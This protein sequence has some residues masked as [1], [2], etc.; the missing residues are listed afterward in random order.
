M[1]IVRLRARE[2]HHCA[3]DI[4]TR[5]HYA[6]GG[7]VTWNNSNS[8]SSS[9]SSNNSSS[10]IRGLS[11][12]QSV[13]RWPD[14]RIWIPGPRCLAPRFL[15]GGQWALK[16]E[17]GARA[18]DYRIGKW[19][20]AAV[21]LFPYAVTLRKGKWLNSGCDAC[22]VMR[23]CNAVARRPGDSPPGMRAR[24]PTIFRYTTNASSTTNADPCKNKQR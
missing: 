22:W 21:H 17:G 3:A 13:S 16:V 2:L 11:E 1:L 19:Q 18:S 15:G 14:P 9:S 23:L 7:R 10:T 6:F 5:T 4:Y 20:P 24:H 8:N 12:G